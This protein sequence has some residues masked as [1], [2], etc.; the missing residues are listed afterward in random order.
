M[1]AIESL[2]ANVGRRSASYVDMVAVEKVHRQAM[3]D[4]P[5]R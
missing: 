3:L 5:R 2:V 1:A 4:K